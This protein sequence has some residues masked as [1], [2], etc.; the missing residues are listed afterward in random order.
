MV[1]FIHLL[2]KI[3]KKRNRFSNGNNSAKY[4]KII[5]LI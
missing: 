5:I 2:N 1:Y 3:Y 4:L